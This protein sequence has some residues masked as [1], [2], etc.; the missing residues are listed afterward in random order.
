MIQ[1]DPYILETAFV[2]PG[3]P[4][5]A[6]VIALVETDSELSP[7]RK[8]DILSGLRRIAKALGR[9]PEDVPADVHWL[10]SRLAHLSPAAIGLSPK[11][12]S[13][14]ISDA[15]AGLI[16]FGV[17]ERRISRKSAL[18]PEWKILWEAALASGDKTIPF[19]LPRLVHFLS[20]LGI[21]PCDVNIDHIE[22]F[23]EAL[24]LN[25]L[26]RSPDQ[27]VR[28][29]VEAWNL[30]RKRLP[31]WPRQALTLPSRA[32]RIKFAPGIF[33]ASFLEELDTYLSSLRDP[34]PLDF[35][36][37]PKPLRST[38]IEQYRSML[39]RFASVVVHAGVPI[40]EITSLSVIAKSRNVKLGLAWM[41]ARTNNQ[42]TA[43]IADTIN[44]LRNLARRH[45]KIGDDEQKQLDQWNVRLAMEPQSGLTPKNRDRLRPLRDEKTLGHLLRLPG[46]LFEGAQEDR[47]R[48]TAAIDQENALAMAILIYC[49][50]RRAN[51]FSIHIDRNLQKTGDGKVFLIFER[52]EVKNG[53]RIEFE[54]PR[55]VV[56]MIDHH[57][58]T[59]SP[60][61][62]PPGTPWLF[63]RRDG[64]GPVAMSNVAERVKR[65]IHR[66][67][68]LTINLHLFR[69]LAV[70]IWLDAHPGQ[71]EV[72]RRLLGHASLSQTLNVYSGFEAGTATRLFAEVIDMARRI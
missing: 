3:T 65:R 1:F 35:N 2:K 68:G 66:E 16:R 59:R 33:P 47:H 44:L 11:S 22:A 64:T 18:S 53:Q 41:L 26:Y 69:H 19:A 45:L 6:D 50:V 21:S 70:M 36:A 15:R 4:M 31:E 56:S 23:R 7:T 20:G 9:P 14:A 57:L 60:R 48:L 46:L 52:D 28:K 51:L 12:W 71:Y 34:D 29:A 67:T 13:N 61:L 27:G 32:K 17:V 42:K 10:R 38:T 8:R 43:G 49:P 72:A 62:C 37:I 55:T 63:P 5:F 54:L 25:E 40:E 58:A 30:A 39:L 24:V